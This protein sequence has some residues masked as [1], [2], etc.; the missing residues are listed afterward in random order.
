M[1]VGADDMLATA[2]EPFAALH[3]DDADRHGVRD[4]QAVVLRSSYGELTVTAA[5]DPGTARGCVFVPRNSTRA[6]A[7]A[8]AGEE[9]GRVRVSLEA[10]DEQVASVF[11]GGDR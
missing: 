1:S 7:T 2:K 9:P 11:G 5:V 3:P 6:P 10:V 4:G 8:L